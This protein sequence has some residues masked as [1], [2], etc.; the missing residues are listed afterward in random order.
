MVY[1]HIHER[2][3]LPPAL[4]DV[5]L[6]A[7]WYRMQQRIFTTDLITKEEELIPVFWLRHVVKRYHPSRSHRKI[8]QRNAAFTTEVLP[9]QL[10]DELEELYGRYRA[11]VD[12][13]VA[14]MLQES[15]LGE[16]S[17]SIYTSTCIEVR[18]GDRLIAAGILDE[19][20]NSIAGIL[21]FYDPAYAAYSPGKYLMLL[22]MEYAQRTG[23]QYYYTGY[24][25]TVYDKFDYKLML[26]AEA[27]E[28]YK[29]EV[30][31]WV[32]WGDWVV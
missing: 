6:A 8:R 4:L 7:G 27:T 9:L 11:A 26:G 22:K 32:V 16:A 29:R 14:P 25:S 28:V 13:E 20:E 24:M 31:T 19:G 3:V 15:L 1:Y 5:Y 12:F 2:D 23:R 17:D 10:T 21:N 18:E 30:N